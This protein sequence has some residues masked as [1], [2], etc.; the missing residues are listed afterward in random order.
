MIVEKTSSLCIYPQ[1]FFTPM[2]WLLFL[3]YYVVSFIG[4]GVVM[5]LNSIKHKIYKSLL[6]KNFSFLIK[7]LQDSLSLLSVVAE[8]KENKD[9]NYYYKKDMIAYFLNHGKFK[10][11]ENS[12]YLKRRVIIIKV[13]Y[14]LQGISQHREQ[15]RYARMM[16]NLNKG[17]HDEDNKLYHDFSERLIKS[18]PKTILSAKKTARRNYMILMFFI[19]VTLLFL[20]A[21]YSIGA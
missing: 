19:L 6:I 21:S 3:C 15:L 18:Y 1:Y 10:R 12:A 16:L 4:L 14:F 8:N 7:S 2:L 13:I 5:V 11:H 20:V 9:F 17:L